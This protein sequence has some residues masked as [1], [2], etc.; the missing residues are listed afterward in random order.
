[1]RKYAKKIVDC[2]M[3]IVIGVGI[4]TIIKTV[5]P[6]PDMVPELIRLLVALCATAFVSEYMKAKS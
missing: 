3:A 4:H 5:F 2:L 1:M 6:D